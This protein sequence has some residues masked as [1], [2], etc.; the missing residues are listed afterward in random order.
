MLVDDCIHLQQAVRSTKVSYNAYYEFK[1]ASEEG[2]SNYSGMPAHKKFWAQDQI[3]TKNKI[4]RQRAHKKS[5][6]AVS[7]RGKSGGT[8]AQ[9]SVGD[10]PPA[11]TSAKS[12]HNKCQR[13]L[14]KK[15]QK[16]RKSQ[17]AKQTDTAA[18]VSST[19]TNTPP[20]AGQ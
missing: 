17:Q 12:R 4:L 3:D 1:M 8:P 10:G 6:A 20:K 19:A 13:E 5:L 15:H 18:K 9:S 7:S 16:A 11:K 14:Y 2:L